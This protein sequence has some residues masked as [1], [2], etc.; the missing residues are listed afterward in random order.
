MRFKK[1]EGIAL[2]API[3]LTLLT[4]GRVSMNLMAGAQN[5][6]VSVDTAASAT[7]V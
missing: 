2:Y 3:P 5:L 6:Q 1:K 7:G 4:L